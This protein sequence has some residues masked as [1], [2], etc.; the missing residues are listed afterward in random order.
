MM[1]RSAAEPC[2][3]T[4]IVE[5]AVKHLRDLTGEQIQKQSFDPTASPDWTT[6][7]GRAAVTVQIE[8]SATIGTRS[9]S[10]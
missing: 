5:F 8:F 3:P 9:S 10:G 6:H 4:E 7:G 2:A 1:F